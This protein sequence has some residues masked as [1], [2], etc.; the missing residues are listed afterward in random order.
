[1]CRFGYELIENII[2]KY[3]EGEIIILNEM[4]LSPEQEL[5]K[6]LVQIMNVFSARM[7]GLRRYKNEIKKQFTT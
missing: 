5:T 6:D 3:S 7:N 4:N 2:N 1:M